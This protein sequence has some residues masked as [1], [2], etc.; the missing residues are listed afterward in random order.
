M[1]GFNF[2]KSLKRQMQKHIHGEPVQRYANA[3]SHLKDTVA[4]IKGGKRSPA[5]KFLADVKSQLKSMLE[6]LVREM[7]ERDMTKLR[8][9]AD[10]SDGAAPPV[11]EFMLKNDVLRTLCQFAK[12]PTVDLIFLH[13][14]TDIV[15]FACPLLNHYKKASQPVLDLL[16]HTEQRVR[17]WDLSKG[18]QDMHQRCLSHGFIQLVYAIAWQLCNAYSAPE[19]VDFFFVGREF[20]FNEKE[21]QVRG[22]GVAFMLLEFTLP[23]LKRGEEVVAAQEIDFAND[24]R[25]ADRTYQIYTSEVAVDALICLLRLQNAH[26]RDYV[27]DK[28]GMVAELVCIGLSELCNTFL[29]HDPD[30]EDDYFSKEMIL[31]QLMR[32]LRLLE[33]VALHPAEALV[34]AFTVSYKKHILEGVFRDSL[35]AEEEA[36]A[37]R[38]NDSRACGWSGKGPV[39]ELLCYFLQNLSIAPFCDDL[40]HL[41]LGIRW[42]REVREGILDCIASDDDEM[43]PAALNVVL[44]LLKK[45]PFLTADVLLAPTLAGA[46]V[47]PEQLPYVQGLSE[48]MDRLF[49]EAL[50]THKGQEDERTLQDQHMSHVLLQ[51]AVMSDAGSAQL[52]LLQWQPIDCSP[53]EDP[54][55][56]LLN[57]VVQ[58]FAT[59]FD[60]TA[61]VTL[62]LLDVVT[63]LIHLNCSKLLWFFFVQDNGRKLSLRQALQTVGTVVEGVRQQYTPDEFQSKLDEVRRHVG[64]MKGFNASR[65]ELQRTEE[66]LILEGALTLEE[67]RREIKAA[68]QVCSETYALDLIV[69]SDAT[70]EMQK[71]IDL[72]DHLAAVEGCTQAA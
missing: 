19:C 49:N 31:E 16:Q 37:D 65:K 29:D 23:Y 36:D 57:L 53:A 68:L 14:I 66:V 18:S 47:E 45:R 34:D 2:V 52:P 15:L 58:K 46:A 26:V 67:W 33:A 32:R 20:R 43:V 38:H 61:E 13:H 30:D 6:L 27:S 63:T 24:F 71:D 9:R 11:Y 59:F 51:A 60:Q 72:P 10:G 1:D 41:L 12:E 48:G 50:F 4:K 62:V 64:I 8:H 39:M 54:D 55:A 35:L 7:K 17:P 28:A 25:E 44:L 21:E 40:A 56:C 5:H 42:G 70:L 3:W 22:S 69:A